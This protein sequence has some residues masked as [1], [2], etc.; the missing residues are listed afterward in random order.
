MEVRGRL[1]RKKSGGLL[2]NYNTHPL[3]YVRYQLYTLNCFI[4]MHVIFSILR[5]CSLV[6]VYWRDRSFT[7][8]KCGSRH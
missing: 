7:S 6:M 2:Q 4:Y 8:L 1:G 5:V 3:L